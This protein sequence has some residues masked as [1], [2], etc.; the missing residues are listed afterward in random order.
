L[1]DRT[2]LITGGAGFIGSYLA[3]ALV[4]HG[5]RVRVLDN[6]EPQAHGDTLAPRGGYDLVVGDVTDPVVVA[7]SLSDVDAVVHFAALVGVGQ[8]M[9]EAARYVRANCVG[10]AV[11]LEE[12]AK[13]RDR[14]GRLVVASSMSIYGEG[15][16][17]CVACEAPREGERDA[18][19]LAAGRWEPPCP[20]C[21]EEL[22]P[23][24]TAETKLPR[25]AS[26]YAVTKRD[27]EELCLAFG[28]AYGIP[29]TALRFFNVYGP[30]QALSN[31]YTGVVAIFAAR[32]LAGLAPLVFEDGGQ[33]RDFV[34]VEDVAA[35]CV[36]ALERPEVDGLALNLGTGRATE[37]GDLARLVRKIV[38]G[39]EP[40]STGRFRPGD[41]RHCVA[42]ATNATRLLGW[43]PKV[44]FEV[45]L[46]EMA[47]WLRS[48]R[49]QK[50]VLDRPYAELARVGLLQ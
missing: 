19:R 24:P 39:R 10:T 43:K 7:R 49:P 12:V 45:G 2:V 31:P 16:Y 20:V 36:A 50:E 15:A 40:V 47:E 41:I 22:R 27:Q 26:V 30:G 17:E 28:R 13:R 21:G 3:P 14:I 35:A 6:L 32:L 44:Q 5:F 25:P 48:Q 38:G 1:T 18:A 9:Y 8:S 11:L 42:D 37:I 33:T 4:R 23:V 29:T 46:A 34:H